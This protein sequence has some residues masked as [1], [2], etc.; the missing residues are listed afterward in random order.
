MESRYLNSSRE[1]NWNRAKRII[2]G[3]R[4]S[5]NDLNA[6]K[7]MNN[8]SRLHRM[9]GRKAVLITHKV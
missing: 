1:K 5:I 8:I 6:C 4:K 2:G 9:L 7:V 3:V